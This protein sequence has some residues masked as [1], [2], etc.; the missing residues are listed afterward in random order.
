MLQVPPGINGWRPG[1]FV[2]C[3][4]D[5]Q[6]LQARVDFC[7]NE[8]PWWVLTGR[9]VTTLGFG[10][11]CPFTTGATSVR[12][13]FVFAD[14]DF[15]TVGAFLRARIGM[16]WEETTFY[17]MP[18][19]LRALGN[20]LLDARV[21]NT[22]LTNS[23]FDTDSVVVTQA[24]YDQFGPA[25]RQ[26]TEHTVALDPDGTLIGL[27]TDVI[28]PELLR[29]AGRVI[30]SYYDATLDVWVMPAI[31]TTDATYT[32]S[33]SRSEV[34][35]IFGEIN[36]LV[37]SNGVVITTLNPDD[38]ANIALH[39]SVS[40]H[41]VDVCTRYQ[42]NAE[43]VVL[44]NVVLNQTQ[45]PYVAVYSQTPVVISGGTGRNFNMINT[46]VIDSSAALAI[47]GGDQLV[48]A[49]EPVVDV[50]GLVLDGIT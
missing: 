41:N 38:R 7:A 45:C 10:D 14:G 2:Y 8:Q 13:C 15:S 39:P 30:H 36:T 4:N 50:D 5:A 26:A 18:Y 11:L 1:K 27:T 49:Y 23:I 29:L 33:L 6:S 16:S 44:S 46:T 21:V 12:Y 3:Q 35:G 28:T 48:Y 9:A 40:V 47:L 31:T 37:D 24:N 22:L 17:Y 32:S 34:V 25:V 20:L 19:T 43:D 42:V